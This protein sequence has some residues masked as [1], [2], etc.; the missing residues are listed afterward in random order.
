[1]SGEFHN[2]FDNLLD[3]FKVSHLNIRSIKKI[4]K[5]RAVFKFNKF[6]FQCDMSF[7][8]MVGMTR[9]L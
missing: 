6:Y 9:V 8:N 7:R 2:F 1:M 5:L 4:L 3:H